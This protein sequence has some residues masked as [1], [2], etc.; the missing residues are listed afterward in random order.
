MATKEEL[1]QKRKMILESISKLEK[2]IIILKDEVEIIDRAIEESED[3][4]SKG[5]YILDLITIYSNNW[6][7]DKSKKKIVESYI[8]KELVRNKVLPKEYKLVTYNKDDELD[9]IYHDER[10]GDAF[11]GVSFHVS[12][13]GEQIFVCLSIIFSEPVTDKER[14]KVAGFS[15]LDNIKQKS[16]DF[17]L[18]KQE[19]AR[20]RILV[21]TKYNTK[22]TYSNQRIEKEFSTLYKYAIDQGLRLSFITLKPFETVYPNIPEFRCEHTN[23]VQ[24]SIKIPFLDLDGDIF[25]GG[26]YVSFY[27]KKCY[28]YFI[29]SKVFNNL[30]VKK[31]IPLINNDAFGKLTKK[32]SGD[33][34]TESILHRCGYNV[35]QQKG[36][37]DNQRQKILAI[38]IRN[39][40]LSK[41]KVRNYLK[42]YIRL[43]R[44]SSIMK[45]A[46]SKWTRDL[47]FVESYKK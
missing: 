11:K 43:N 16:F 38:V 24:K 32:G 30:S 27:C 18:Y 47:L 5:N 7:D 12:K 21:M 22:Y 31:G 19:Y 37:S 14:E 23:L 10:M 25:Y 15:A 3:A 36:L 46:I 44:N 13:S 45:T 34:E 1:E 9:V 29:D 26:P 2:Q 8:S 28:I 6:A 40:L 42:F 35:N 17:G 20:E 33:L 41:E 39:N 4:S